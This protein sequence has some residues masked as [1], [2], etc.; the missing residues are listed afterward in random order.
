MSNEP[1][2][3]LEELG[4][5]N[6]MKAEFDPTAAAGV[7]GVMTPVNS[8]IMFNPKTQYVGGHGTTVYNIRPSDLRREAVEGVRHYKEKPREND[9]N[10]LK[11]EVADLKQQIAMLTDMMSKKIAQPESKPAKPAKP[12]EPAELPYL[13][14]LALAKE[15]D[16]SI[17]GR[18]SALKLKAIIAD[19]VHNE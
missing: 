19:G 2:S 18:P 3:V 7:D 14:L 1:K 10:V 16:P 11:A 12:I 5:T 4:Y 17:K 13:E 15:T 8:N 9:P 6:G